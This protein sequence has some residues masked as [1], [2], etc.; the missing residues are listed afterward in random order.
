MR[1]ILS[2]IERVP[3]S[4][5]TADLPSRKPEHEAA[6]IIGGC[7]VD[8]NVCMGEFAT[9]IMILDDLPS[10]VFQVGT[11]APFETVASIPT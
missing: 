10:S 11:M 7:V 1:W 6:E 4:A 3:S 8:L 5:N 9:E 2:W